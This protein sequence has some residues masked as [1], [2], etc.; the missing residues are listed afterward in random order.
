[1]N[2]VLGKK[3]A[4]EMQQNNYD[5][6]NIFAK[7]LRNEIPCQK[8]FESEWVLSFYDR[9]PKAPVHVLVIP[10]HASCHYT[11]FI[12]NAPQEAKNGFFSGIQKTLEHL[13]LKSYRLVTNC[14]INS[15]QEVPH[16]HM[17][18]LGGE[19]LGPLRC[20]H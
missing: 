7:I 12:L 17:H 18:I 15:G 3:G 1:M 11:D 13:E 8:V 4:Q 5:P 10:K 2:K 16:F 19:P 20:Q 6:Q 14:G 9:F